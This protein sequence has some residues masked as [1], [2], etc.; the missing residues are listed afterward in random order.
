MHQTGIYPDKFRMMMVCIKK[1]IK[2]W[3]YD[4]L[5][6]FEYLTGVSSN[7][8]CNYRPY[9]GNRY[10]PPSERKKQESEIPF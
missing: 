1:G 4:A 7:V 6:Y 2:D 10:M 9:F 5:N 3:D 8:P